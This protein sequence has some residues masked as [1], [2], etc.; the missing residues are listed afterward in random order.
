[1]REVKQFRKIMCNIQPLLLRTQGRLDLC[2]RVLFRVSDAA[3]AN[4]KTSI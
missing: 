2:W 4:L 1:M 3:N